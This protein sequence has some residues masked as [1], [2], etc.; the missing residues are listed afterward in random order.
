MLGDPLSWLTTFR[1]LSR[2]LQEN[3][4][5]VPQSGHEL[6]LPDFSSSSIVLPFD[7]IQPDLPTA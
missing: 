4:G 1:G 2:S 5:I 7:A 6:F 3:S